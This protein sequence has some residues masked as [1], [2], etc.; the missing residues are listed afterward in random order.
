MNKKSKVVAM[1]E[2]LWDIFPDK[3][4]LGGAPLNFLYYCRKFDVDVNLVSAV[5]GDELGAELISKMKEHD[6]NDKYLQKSA[7]STSTVQI[8][9]DKTGQPS[10]EITENVAWDNIIFKEEL[11]ELAEKTSIFYFGSLACRNLITK[12]TIFQFAKKLPKEAIKICDVNIRQ[13]YYSKEL[14]AELLEL[15]DVLKINDEELVIMKDFFNISREIDEKTFL[16]KLLDKFGLKLII[17]TK[18]EKGSLLFSKDEENELATE[19][20]VVSDTVGAGDSFAAVI[21]YGLLN[22]WSLAK[23]NS[24]ASKL[25][26]FVCMQAGA[27]PKIENV[28]DIIE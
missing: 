1:G 6:I 15:A 25:A 27:T 10:Y 5:G 14:L 7:F 17:L 4:C 11:I 18:G 9:L 26:S 8:K 12:S 20:V 24:V 28:W 16:R 13:K 23:M 3:K 22:G 19:L 21:C 2:A